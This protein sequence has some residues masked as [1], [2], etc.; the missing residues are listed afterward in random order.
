MLRV[1]R[2]LLILLLLFVVA[3]IAAFIYLRTSLPQVRGS[4]VVPGISQSV[5]IVRDRHGIPHIFAAS[6]EDAYFALGFAHAQDRLWQMEFQR[7]VGA[8]RLAE[9]VGQAA[10]GTDRFLR[11]L[12]VYHYAERAFEALSADTQQGIQAYVAGVNAHLTT[13]RGP[14]PPEFLFFRHTPELF[15]PADVLVW[16]KM[17][18][19]DL[20]GNWDD[21]VLRARLL[22]RL[23]AAQIADLWPAY[24]ADAPIILPDFADHY[25]QLDLDGLWTSSLRPLPPE[26]GSNNWVVSGERSISGAPLL[27]ND[28]HLGLGTP[29]LWYFAH[30]NA[31]GFKVIGATLPGTPSVLL[32]RNDRIAWGFTNTGPDVQDLFI[33]QLNPDNALEYLTPDGYQSFTLREEVIRVKGGEDVQLTVRESRH[34]PIISDVSSN[35]ADAA[36]L[37]GASHVLAFRW[38]ALDADDTTIQA[39]SNLASA[40]NWET[41]TEALR[42]YVV[43]QQNIVYA[44]IDGNIGYYAPGRIPI[45]ASGDGSIPV[46]G[47]DDEYAWLDYIPFEELPHAFNPESG[48]IMTANHKV[49]PDDYPHF[50]THDWAEPYRAKRIDQLLGRINKH[51]VASFQSIQMDQFSLMA[52]EFLPYLLN[53]RAETALERS[54]Q[55]QLLAWDGLMDKDQAAPLIFAAWYRELGR[56]I[57][58]DELGDF[59]ADYYGFRPMFKR[60]VLQGT[61]TANWCNDIRTSAV[62]S[63]EFLMER[64]FRT[65]LDGLSQ[66]Y[67]SDVSRWRWGEAHVAYFDHSVFSNTPLAALFDLRIPNGGDPFTI[68]AARFQIAA[69]SKPFRQTNGPGYRAVYDLSNLDN[70]EF[71]HTTGQSGNPLSMRYRNFVGL[72]RDG[73]YLPMTTDRVE[74]ERG[75]IG[76]LTLNPS[77]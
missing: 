56:L 19:W 17:M 24:P 51:S 42:D 25:R 9:V 69:T 7:R 59:F 26:S 32:G 39:I 55:A 62:E 36:R 75:R 72:W 63:C 20:G 27:A 12:S 40:T 76:T 21:E 8:G 52:A 3:A 61:S 18:A 58:A 10:L 13:R 14:L 47:W 29:S 73:S 48:V 60:N 38:S 43:P 11:T 49:V 6:K 68:N 67:G 46:P 37:S 31:P 54:A 70:S 23:S 4:L 74:I 33:E 22:Q 5:E 65:A 57:Y 64:A 30:L 16:G 66:S 15:Q 34:G 50:I 45:R 28:P 53:L 41:F 2:V 77:P 35:A 44:D 1:L 71:I